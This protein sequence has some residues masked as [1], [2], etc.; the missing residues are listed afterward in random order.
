MYRDFVI[1]EATEMAAS[2]Y[3]I[4]RDPGI[5]GEDA[6]AFRPERWLAPPREGSGDENDRKTTG[7]EL[8][9]DDPRR[10]VQVRIKNMEKFGMW[11]GYGSR[12]CAGK[13]LA[14]MQMRKVCLEILRRFE[15][16]QVVNEEGRSFKYKRWGVGMY[17]EQRMVFKARKTMW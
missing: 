16:G 4:H 1:P 14:Q 10:A 3:I 7:T 8:Q 17:W 15:V 13:N 2:P 6:E 11:W 9:Q 12:T 5:F